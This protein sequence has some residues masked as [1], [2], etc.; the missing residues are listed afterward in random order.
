MRR[1]SW[2]A[3]CLISPDSKPPQRLTSL[4][5][6]EGGPSLPAL[7]V[8]PDVTARGKHR[9]ERVVGLVAPAALDTASTRVGCGC[10]VQAEPVCD[11][12]LKGEALG[13]SSRELALLF[14]M[15]TRSS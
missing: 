10:R 6:P 2:L 7:I 9:Q 15:A 4:A 13:F 5:P 1:I 11:S 14:P 3:S 8:H 12:I